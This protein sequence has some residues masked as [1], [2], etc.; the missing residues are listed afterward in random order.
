[1]GC[2]ALR[3]AG[4]DGAI[5]ARHAVS[6]GRAADI[7]EGVFRKQGGYFV[8]R[9]GYLIR[10]R[11][12][13][14]KIDMRLE[15][16]EDGAPGKTLVLAYASSD[17]PDPRIAQRTLLETMREASGRIDALIRAEREAA[18]R[19]QPKPASAAPSPAASDRRPAPVKPAARSVVDAA[20]PRRALRPK[21]VALVVGI[22]KYRGQEDA[23]FAERDAQIMHAYLLSLGVSE[24]RAI[25]LSGTAATRKNLSYYL[26]DWLAKNVESDSRV[27]FY[28]AGNG[29]PDPRT[30]KPY[31]L[32]WDGEALYVDA[33]GYSLEKLYARLESLDAAETIAVLDAGFSGGGERS[34][35]ARGHS[36]LESLV[37][38]KVAPGSSLSVL[39]AVSGASSAPVLRE[40]SH[41]LFT[42][43]LLLGIRGQGDA[44]KDGRLSLS[45]LFDFARSSAQNASRLGGGNPYIY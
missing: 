25:L 1:M 26:D 31:L 6:I 36:K 18:A 40:E 19:A 29:A 12:A 21:D 2:S 5:E 33:S 28:F 4:R 8:V 34:V 13:F 7:Y 42:Y 11:T 45:E 9:E 37:S 43:R 39:S 32:P 35:I 17:L 30:G 15:F 14:P 27:Y 20:P 41:G 10:A 22:E 44:D 24:N 23:P 16:A 38:P 3:Q